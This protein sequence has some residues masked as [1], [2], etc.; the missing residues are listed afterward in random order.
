MLGAWSLCR[1]YHPQ[2]VFYRF[3]IGSFKVKGFKPLY[4]KIYEKKCAYAR[5]F[6]YRFIFR[7]KKGQRTE[8]VYEWMCVNTKVISEKINSRHY[9][10]WKGMVRLI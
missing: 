4:N 3:F 2:K 6:I 9:L 5:S 7:I 1:T 8:V 10:R